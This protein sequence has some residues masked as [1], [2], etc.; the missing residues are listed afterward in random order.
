[1]TAADVSFDADGLVK[2]ELARQQY[3]VPDVV[4]VR[5]LVSAGWTSAQQ[6]A[7]D[8]FNAANSF[9]S[10]LQAAANSAMNLS[11]LDTS[12]ASLTS[13]ITAFTVFT[14]TFPQMSPSI[15][16]TDAD[17][18]SPE[19][20]HLI[21]TLDTWVLGADTG[22]PAAVEAAL[23]DRARA[24]EI[25]TANK[26]AQ[27]A[28]RQFAS[29]GFSKPPGALAIQLLDVA[30]EAQN[31]DSSF[32]RDVAIKQADLQQTNRRFAFETAEKLQTSLMQIFRDKMQRALE[33]AK[34]LGQLAVEVDAHMAQAYG[35][36]AGFAGGLVGAQ[37]QISRAGVDL[38]IAKGN[39][40]LEASR[41]NLQALIQKATLIV[42]SI[43]AS[44]QIQGQLAASALSAVNLSGGIHDSTSWGMSVSDSRSRSTSVGISS[45]SNR[46]E[47]YTP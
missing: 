23:W 34:T 4:Q 43:R 21:S 7:R 24:R 20:S 47:N 44:A 1:M 37:G 45:S 27:E 46:Q 13:A 25:V 3:G 8:A 41:A 14:E 12:L 26:K 36:R 39:L 35:A 9:L 17:Y 33:V 15:S 22:L 5:G 6:Y 19:L 10:A 40:R 29:R 32:S 18:T 28:L 2:Q 38:E 31:N 16:F 42:E 11:P 30:Q